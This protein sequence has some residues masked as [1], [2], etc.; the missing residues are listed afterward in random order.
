L[1]HREIGFVSLV[2]ASVVCQVTCP[3]KERL[4][5]RNKKKVRLATA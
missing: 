2:M 5:V 1:H 4:P 3:W